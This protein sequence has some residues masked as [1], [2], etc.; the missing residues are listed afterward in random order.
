MSTT[1]IENQANR[2]A[3][4]IVECVERAD[5]LVTLARIHVRSPVHTRVVCWVGRLRGPLMRNNGA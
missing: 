1:E 3:D 4:A 5:G 2:I